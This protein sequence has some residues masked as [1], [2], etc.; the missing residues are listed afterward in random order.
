MKISFQYTGLIP[1]QNL[2]NIPP[3]SSRMGQY[4]SSGL[5]NIVALLGLSNYA[6]NV[7]NKRNH[8]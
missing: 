7:G 2:N 4:D 1:N 8:F 5:E 6:H 3:G